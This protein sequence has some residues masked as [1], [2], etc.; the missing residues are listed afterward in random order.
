MDWL[1]IEK[2]YV[3]RLVGVVVQG[4]LHE[5]LEQRLLAVLTRATARLRVLL[6]FRRRELEPKHFPDNLV[7]GFQSKL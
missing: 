3:Q 5:H 7:A 1:K 4:T 2:R 6:L